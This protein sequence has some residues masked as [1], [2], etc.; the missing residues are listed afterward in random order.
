MVRVANTRAPTT[1]CYDECGMARVRQGMLPGKVVDLFR[2]D[3]RTVTNFTAWEHESGLGLLLCRDFV[4][5]QVNIL[6][7]A[8]VVDRDDLPLPPA[9]MSVVR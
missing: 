2:L 4:G 6:G 3:R 7:V 8:S 9:S 5:R 1:P